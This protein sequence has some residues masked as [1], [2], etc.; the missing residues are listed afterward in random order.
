MIVSLAQQEPVAIDKRAP[1]WKQHYELARTADGAPYLV[2][3][4][5]ARRYGAWTADCPRL[6]AREELLELVR[7]AH[8]SSSHAKSQVML[9]KLTRYSN[10]SRA[11]C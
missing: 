9:K 2:R 8:I 1:M 6:C 3:K 7:D 4:A 5:D 10:I 11:I